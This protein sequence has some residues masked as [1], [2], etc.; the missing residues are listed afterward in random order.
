MDAAFSYAYTWMLKIEETEVY[1]SGLK[2]NNV[3]WRME[4]LEIGVFQLI[5]NNNFCLRR[6]RKENY[7]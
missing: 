7:C 5:V 1:N 6:A 2:F 3:I 4:F